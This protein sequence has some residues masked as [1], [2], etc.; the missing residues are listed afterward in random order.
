M[1]QYIAYLKNFKTIH[2]K[3]VFRPKISIV[4]TEISYSEKHYAAPHFAIYILS[5]ILSKP[6][7]VAS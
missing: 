7:H 3:S 5:V 6:E 4:P 2:E 1:K